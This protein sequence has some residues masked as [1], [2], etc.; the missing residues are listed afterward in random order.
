MFKASPSKEV[1]DK[2]S[3]KKGH[4]K[5]GMFGKKPMGKGKKPFSLFGKKP[6]MAED[7][8]MDEM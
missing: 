1:A 8:D 4:S 7:T 2:I 3:K 6:M 5:K